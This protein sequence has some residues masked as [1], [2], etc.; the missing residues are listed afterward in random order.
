MSF[1]RR[2]A[3]L[4]V[5]TASLA[6]AAPGADDTSGPAPATPPTPLFR[7]EGKSRDIVRESSDGPATVLTIDGGTGIGQATISRLADQ[8]PREIIVRARLRG[9]E[10][11]VISTPKL[12]LEISVLSHSGHPA[13]LHLRQ[14]N[15]PNPPPPLT[16]DS[17][18][19]TD[20][21]CLDPTGKP[22]AER[23]PPPQ[24]CFELRVPPAVLTNSATFD[25]KWI[26]FY[27]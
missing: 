16:K 4:F 19:W 6:T 8:W 14:D 2:L 12:S 25:L 22:V 20:V 18:F 10:S 27:R 9:L 1:R 23:K 11:L 17:P 13:L 24:G 15:Q 26:D 21:R 3:L 5:A 7:I